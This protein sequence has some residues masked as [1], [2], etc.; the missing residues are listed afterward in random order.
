LAGAAYFFTTDFSK[1]QPMDHQEQHHEQ[2]RKEREH[3]KQL[4]KEH[5]HQEEKSMLPMHPAW[6]MVLGGLL[7]IAVVLVWTWVF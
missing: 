5:E 7:I 2:H 1:G 4:R 3:E 6:F